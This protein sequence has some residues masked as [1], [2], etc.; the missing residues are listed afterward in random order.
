MSQMANRL[1]AARVRDLER[2]YLALNADIAALRLRLTLQLGED[3]LETKQNPNW[4]DQP[5]A[6][7][8][9]PDGG[10]WVAAGG[11]AGGEP[12][13]GRARDASKTSP[14]QPPSWRGA[15]AKSCCQAI[16]VFISP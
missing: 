7:A 1:P 13:S 5:R 8:A 15:T 14:I 4:R 2:R 11:G 9:A 16:R 10:Q 12:A 3:P 6:P